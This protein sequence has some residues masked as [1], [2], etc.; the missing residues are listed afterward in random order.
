MSNAVQPATKL[1]EGAQWLQWGNYHRQV[2]GW[3]QDSDVTMIALWI[4]IFRKWNFTPKEMIAATECLLKRSSP[5]FKREDH[6]NHLRAAVFQQRETTQ[7]KRFESSEEYARGVCTYC[8]N[9]GLVSVPYLRDVEEGQWVTNRTSGVWCSCADGRPYSR[10]M[11]EQEKKLMGIYEYQ[12]RNPNWQKQL[13]DKELLN[14]QIAT[15]QA[16]GREAIQGDSIDNIDVILSAM[17]A[18]FGLTK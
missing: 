1:S 18:R 3:K 8:F 12:T 17:R 13:K 4:G 16:A 2:F 10:S 6:I 11:T 7:L 15:A 9:S 14:A 5:V